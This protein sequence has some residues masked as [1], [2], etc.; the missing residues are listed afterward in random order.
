MTKAQCKLIST[1]IKNKQKLPKVLHFPLLVNGKLLKSY[2]Y[3][4]RARSLVVSDLRSENKSSRFE[5]G[6]YL[7]AEV[8]SAVIARLMSQCL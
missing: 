5:C 8:N 1:N 2:L 7:C 4:S 6:C 3:Y